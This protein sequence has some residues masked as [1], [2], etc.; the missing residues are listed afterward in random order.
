MAFSKM[1]FWVGEGGFAAFSHPNFPLC[2]RPGAGVRGWGKAGLSTL[3]K[4]W[5]AVALGLSPRF[6]CVIMKFIN[7][8]GR[9][10]STSG[11]GGIPGA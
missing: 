9:S 6:F 8:I 5:R 11:C 1:G 10:L 7:V 3:R 2:P 4:P